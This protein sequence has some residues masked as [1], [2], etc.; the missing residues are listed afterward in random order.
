MLLKFE[1]DLGLITDTPSSRAIIKDSK[2]VGTIYEVHG[3]YGLGLVRNEHAS[4]FD[5]LKNFIGNTKLDN[6]I[7]KTNDGVNLTAHIV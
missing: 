3:R 4:P 6:P 5:G 2:T 1:N 7:L